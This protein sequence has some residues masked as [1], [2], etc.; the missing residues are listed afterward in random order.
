MIITPVE[1]VAIY[2]HR[3]LLIQIAMYEQVLQEEEQIIITQ[4]INLHHLQDIEAP[5]VLLEEVLVQNQEQHIQ[6]QQQQNDT[7]HK[8]I[9]CKYMCI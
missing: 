9:T 6:D 3:D 8:T 7:H 1:D 5:V 2:L 4:A